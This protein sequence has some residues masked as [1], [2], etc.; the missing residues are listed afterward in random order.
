MYALHTLV[1]LTNLAKQCDLLH[2]LS[3]A[4]GCGGLNPV[5]QVPADTHLLFINDFIPIPSSHSSVH[6]FQGQLF[7]SQMG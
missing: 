1:D 6:S 3:V 4:F 5:E 2:L 7:P